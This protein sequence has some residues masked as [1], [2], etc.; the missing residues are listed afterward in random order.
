MN[1]YI[2]NK[3]TSCYYNIINKSKSRNL[4]K[5]Y[6]KHHIIPKSL[7]GS[8]DISNLVKL[9]HR[10]HYI[11][12]WLL[13]KM[14]QNEQKQKMIYA[15]WR[16]NNKQNSYHNSRAYKIS[17][18]LF[19]IN[20]T[21]QNNP[22]FGKVSAYKGRKDSPETL[23]KKRISNTGK[24]HTEKTKLKISQGRLGKNNPNYKGKSFTEETKK[25][26]SM[27]AKNRKRI[28]CPHCNALTP[29]NVSHR[30]HFNNCKFRDTNWEQA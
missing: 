9:T 13:I 26:L 7:G 4:T 29:I 12:H 19:Q 5:N 15:F 30:W 20:N 6:E 16:M 2:S 8:N 17:R 18:E 21:G 24:K 11:V 25:K 27:I 22:M 14:T 1:I 3:Y 28:S 10:E 23:E